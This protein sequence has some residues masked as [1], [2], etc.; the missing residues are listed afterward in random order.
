ME[1]IYVSYLE[2]NIPTIQYICKQLKLR[3][4]RATEDQVRHSI[5]SSVITCKDTNGNYTGSK[6][7]LWTPFHGR[8]DLDIIE[9]YFKKAEYSQQNIKN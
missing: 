9:D 2:N 8:S 3:N 6:R 1:D 7:M 5:Q 4:I